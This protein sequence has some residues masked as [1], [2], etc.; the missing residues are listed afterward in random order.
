MTGKQV[1]T[2]PNAVEDA[3]ALNM[4][5]YEEEAR[6]VYV[7]EAPATI[8]SQVSTSKGRLGRISTTIVRQSKPRCGPK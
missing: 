2:S 5:N 3:C 1:V 7:S 8:L 6:V 4:Y